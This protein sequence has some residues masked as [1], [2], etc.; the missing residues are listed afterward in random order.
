MF[1]HMMVVFVMS[2][3]VIVDAL[4]SGHLGAGQAVTGRVQLVIRIP[5]ERSFTTY[6]R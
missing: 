1:V 2:V 4:L 3:E 6:L 5:F